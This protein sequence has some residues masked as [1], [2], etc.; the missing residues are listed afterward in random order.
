MKIFSKWLLICFSGWWIS[1]GELHAQYAVRH[2]GTDDGL[3]QG[4][5]YYMLEDKQGFTWLTTQGGLNRFDGQVIKSFV[6][7]E[8]DS[9]SISKGEVR[10]LAESP[11]GDI[12]M[13]TEVA[14][15]RY[16]RKTNRFRNYFVR[17]AAGKPQLSHH[18]VVYADDSTVLYLNDQEGLAR[19]NYRSGH[20]RVLFK[21]AGF[22]YG[23]RTDVVHYDALAQI[24]WLALPKGILKLDCKSG[25]RS[26]FFTGRQDDQ[27]DLQLHVY[28]MFADRDKAIWL[29]TDKGLVKLSNNTFEI[30]ETGVDMAAD[31]VFSLAAGE[32]GNVWLATSKSGLV[33]Y[34]P[35]QR[36]V[37]HQLVNDPFRPG[38]LARDHVSKVFI[39]S[40]N[41]VWANTDPAGV[42][43]VFPKSNLVQ[44]YEDDPRNPADFNRASV[45]GIGQDLDGNIWVGTSG[46]ELRKIT[47][48][49]VIRRFGPE[50][51]FPH[52]SVRGV[53]CDSEGNTWISTVSSLVFVK[54]GEE[55]FKKIFFDG[56]DPAKCNYIKG[57]LEIAS[58]SFL[59]ATMGGIYSYSA[60]SEK[61]LTAPTEE[62]SGSMYYD[63]QSRQ[64]FAGRSEKDLRCFDFRGDTL[65]PLY[66][67]LPGHNIL[68]LLP[69]G[70]Q[71]G[72]PFIWIGTDNGLVKFDRKAR[73]VVRSFSV[74]DGLP[75]HVIYAT[76]RDSKGNMWMS[77]NKGIARMTRSGTFMAI[78]QTQGIEFNS[79]AFCKTRS[80]NLYFGSAQG[81]FFCHPEALARSSSRGLRIATIS[82]NDS[83]FHHSGNQTGLMKIDL[84]YRENNIV[85]ELSA[86]DYMAGVAPL[87]EYRR[88]DRKG[89]Q[90]WV[91]NGTLPLVSFQNLS[92]DTYHYE[93]RALDANGFYTASKH[94]VIIV[95]PPFWRKWWFVVITCLAVAGLIYWIVKIY[96]RQQ[97][98]A[99]QKLSSR[100]I[101]A[102]ESERLR[103]AMDIHDDVNNTLAAAKG[104]LQSLAESQKDR[105]AENIERSRDLIL[106]ATEDLRNIT[107]DLMP[108]QF[109]KYNLPEVLEK[110]VQEW[111]E[112]LEIHFT[113]IFAGNYVKLRAESELMVYRVLTEIVN[114]IKKHSRA[115][116]SIVQLI[117][118]DKSLVVSIEDNGVG[119]DQSIKS[120]HKT[121]GIGL[122]NIY[123]RVEYLKGDLEIT[124]DKS[125]VLVHLIVPYDFNRNNTG[126]SG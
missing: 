54:R 10:G 58:G 102:Q 13:G 109:E 60:G 57:V 124:S 118:Q 73:R 97:Q 106:K 83:V 9:G 90:K 45:R 8:A 53:L 56:P 14:L 86:L 24:T 46:E 40:R 62:F 74:E 85:F 72:N 115:T 16:E 55:K 84:P 11:Q 70:D 98:L 34:D 20:R 44:K 33:L 52:A 63:T 19:L 107:H 126:P 76:V 66:D 112:G 101:S 47:K 37:V 30:H 110:R 99:H 81:L 41:F 28:A 116:H 23:S 120:G 89:S 32:D 80:G 87:F 64:L 88:V 122:K 18:Q 22:T 48:E 6:H 117:Y 113:Y 25:K 67:R 15:S 93:F 29:S 92:P 50:N 77:T 82:V 31:L 125:G 7:H 59:I 121:M 108:V 38:S 79:F 39:D 49:G 95:N 42:D 36:K 96:I 105:A 75:D 100:V 26:Y 21:D 104:Y 4:S 119:F 12:W 71:A 43:I 3:I 68:T 114:N 69:D 2:L 35:T 61:L 78:R 123:S 91:S 5:V 51:G 1:I 17:D 65:V 103:I 27:L 94:V 111:N